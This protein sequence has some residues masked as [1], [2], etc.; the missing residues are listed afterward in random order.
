M[1]TIAERPA[2]A[3]T[4]RE[5]G[6]PRTRKEDEHFLTGRTSWTDN[7]TLPG[8]L[9][10]AILRSPM[11]HA[12][13]TS[14][15]VSG[16]AQRP[17]VIAAFSGRDFADEQGTIPCAWPVTEDTVNPGHPSIAVDQVNHVGEAVAIVVARDKASAEDALEA[18]EIDYEPL[19]V[20]L[21]MEAAIAEG[22]PLVHPNT[23]SNRSYTWTFD[24]RGRPA[25]V[26]RSTR[27][28][29]RPR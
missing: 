5:I 1:T 13:I 19:P 26:S 11:A 8:M 24:V 29:R 28:C 22:A 17:G 21:D 9:H 6:K 20:V 14:V 10:L 3:E 27:R 16:A 18:I 12:K 4:P 25:L 7:I 15:D 23:Q 2:A